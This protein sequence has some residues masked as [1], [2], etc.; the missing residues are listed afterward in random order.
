[1]G[2]GWVS[3]KSKEEAVWHK[4]I[5]ASVAFLVLFLLVVYPLSDIMPQNCTADTP[6]LSTKES[7]LE[8]Y[9]KLP[10][11]FIQNQGQLDEA[12]EYYVRASAQTLYFTEESIV[13]DLTRYNQAE[14]NGTADRQAERLV[15]S[16]DFLG[17]NSQPTIE[18]SGKGSAVVNYLIGNDPEKWRTNVPTYREVVYHDIYP[19]I[20]LRLSGRGM[21]WNMS[22]WSGLE[23]RPRT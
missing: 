12:V 3:L 6:A 18:G 8:A 4:I 9:G 23:Q 22:L 7:I 13:L 2:N 1:M 11:L 15:F 14:T 16:L 19:A 5:L 10:I 21:C 20:D 17:A